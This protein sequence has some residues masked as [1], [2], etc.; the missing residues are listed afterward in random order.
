ME[1]ENLVTEEVTENVEMPTEE[2]KEAVED[3]ELLRPL[4][5]KYK[6]IPQRTMG[7]T[8]K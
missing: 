2:V 4:K 6:G 7:C 3:G 1:K 5:F 8:A